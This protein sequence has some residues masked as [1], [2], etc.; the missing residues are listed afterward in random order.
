M[1]FLHGGKERGR[2]AVSKREV[3]KVIVVAVHTVHVS[4]K[5]ENKTN[6]EREEKQR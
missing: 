4:T 3:C 1:I 5:G 2:N 6:E